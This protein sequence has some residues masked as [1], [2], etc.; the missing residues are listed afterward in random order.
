MAVPKKK[1]S[2]QKRNARRSHL[3]LD[4]INFSKCTNC[5]HLKL[6]HSVCETCGYYKGR[7]IPQRYLQS[8]LAVRF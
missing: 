5:G 7:T 3:A 2:K 6:P 8:Q 4:P 1:T